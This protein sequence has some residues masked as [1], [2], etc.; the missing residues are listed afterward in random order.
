MLNIFINKFCL[1]KLGTPWWAILG[2]LPFALVGIFYGLLIVVYGTAYI[3]EEVSGGPL[4]FQY[5]PW[6]LPWNLPE[7]TFTL[8][9]EYILLYFVS[10][11]IVLFSSFLMS[12]IGANVGNII[13]YP[14]LKLL[15]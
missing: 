2:A 6:Y 3:A 1:I 4:V 5:F 11:I 8:F 12:I 10:I 14:I 15:K 13:G 9:I 7:K